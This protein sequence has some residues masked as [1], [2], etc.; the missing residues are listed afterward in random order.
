VLLSTALLA[1]PLSAVATGVAQADGRPHPA[2]STCRQ[3]AVDAYGAHP[4]DGADDGP[5]IRRAIADAVAATDSATCVTFS[6]G[7]YDVSPSPDGQGHLPISGSHGMSLVGDTSCAAG[8]RCTE[9]RL[10]DPLVRGVLWS[11]SDGAALSD[12]VVDYATPPF[13]QGRASTVDPT[14]CTFTYTP[15]AGYPL[16][17]DPRFTGPTWGTVRDPANPVLLKP[18]SPLLIGLKSWTPVG[19]AYTVTVKPAYCGQLG[20]TD[21]G[22]LQDGDYFVVGARAG[23]T[24]VQSGPAIQF[25][26]VTGATVTR[27]TVYSAP[28]TA[29]TTLNTDGLVVD[30]LQVRRRPGTNRLMSTSADGVH[31]Q[32]ARS[33]PVIE[34]SLLEGMNDDGINVYTSPLRISQVISDTQVRA[35]AASSG[36]NSFR[37]GDP[38]TVFDPRTGS[39]RGPQAFTTVQSITDVVSSADRVTATF[40]LGDPVSGMVAGTTASNSDQIYLRDAAP[41][42]EIRNNT[43][44][45]NRRYGV[46]LKTTGATSYVTGNTFTDNSGSAVVLLND[47]DWPEGPPAQNVTISRNTI[48]RAAYQVYL[49]DAD[50]GGAIVVKA[51]RAGKQLAAQRLTSGIS[52][53]ANTI[54]DP[55]RYAIYVGSAQAVNITRGNLI[56]ASSGARVYADPMAA[57][58]LENAATVTVDDLTVSDQRP[59][60]AGI[61]I[62]ADVAAG[63]GGVT[64]GTLTMD[65]APGVPVIRDD[66]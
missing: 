13:V 53:S 48:T 31:V 56:Q 6:G 21:G 30:G 3:F 28:G 14:T 5:A 23:E 49:G 24:S 35:W 65:L 38:V 15:D 8:S 45:E 26:G 25:N 54:N 55:P 58:R 42:T 16:L 2:V 64:T 36:F 37:V 43:I 34:N 20:R 63:T 59:L 29:V 1:L 4:G 51:Q 7:V 17:A 47:P 41:G 32:G 46:L 22:G 66:R 11:S 50:D 61:W 12:L 27:S 33:G 60:A 62:A 10:S 40:T 57:V 39:M 9:L 18:S 19:A 44:R 52:I